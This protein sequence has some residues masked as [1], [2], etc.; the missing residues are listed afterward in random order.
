MATTIDGNVIAVNTITANKLLD[1]TS[2]AVTQFAQRTN[3]RFGIPFTSWRV[4]DAM[5]TNLPGTSATDD[6]GLIGGTFATA[7]P[8]IQTSDLKTV[9]AT[10]YARVVIALPHN[11]QD[12]QTVT[13]R[14]H[15]GMKTTIADG[16]ATLDV[17]C[18]ESDL[19]E[20]IGADL[21]TTAAIDINSVTLAD[22]DFTITPTGLVKGDVLDIRIAIAVVDTATGTAVIGIIGNAEVLIDCQ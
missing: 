22:R 13:L 21:C 12:G 10:R 15:A 3:S 7:S 14:F 18:Y 17:Q 19:E 4:W 11:Y 16:S 5:H 1:P 8:T 20:G 9:T 2:L 6:L